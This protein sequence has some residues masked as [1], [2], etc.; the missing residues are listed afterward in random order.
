LD[1]PFQSLGTPRL[2]NAG[3]VA[4]AAT[5]L[6]ESDIG[7]GVWATDPQ[8]TLAPVFWVGMMLDVNPDPDIDEFY[9]ILGFD[10]AF[11]FNDRGDL[12]VILD[13]EFRG[14]AAV[15]FYTPAPSA[16]ALLAM[17]GFCLRRRRR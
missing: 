2:N 8:G 12:L 17:A 10:D 5:T 9:R 1:E 7:S 3:Q 4:F 11:V 6:G 13:L 15:I 14:D 16:S